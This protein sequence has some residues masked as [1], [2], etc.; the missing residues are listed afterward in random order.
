VLTTCILASS[1]AFVD[2]SVV[3]VGLPAIG[4]SL[5]GSAAD[6]QWIVNAYLLPLSALLLLGGALGDR[7]GRRGILIFGVALFGIGSAGCAAAPGVPS[8]LAARALQGIGAALLLPNSLAILGSAFSG[9]A[10]GRAVGT[11]SAS[12]S[13]AAAL[14]PVLG[15]W[16]IDVVGWRAIFLLN[17][18]LAAGAIALAALFVREPEQE[19][20]PARLDFAGALLASLALGA[21]TWGLTVGSGRAGWSTLAFAAI[22][23]GAVLLLAFLWIERARGDAAMMPL[24][25]FASSDYVGLTILTALLYGALG[26]LLVLVPYLL[27]QGMGFSGTAAGAALVPFPVV[28]A[29]SSRTMGGIAGRIG[30]RLPLSIGPAIVGIG[31]LLLLRVADGSNYWSAIFPALLAISVGMAG[32]V[33]PLTT[34]VLMSVDPRHMGSASGLNSAVARTGG[35]IATAL[36]GGVFAAKGAQLFAA[37]H[38][39]V[40]AC[41]IASIAAGAAAFL[42]V[43]R[44]T[45][46]SPQQAA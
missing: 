25:I 15:G 18:P 40:I 36:L 7:F 28:L 44:R 41:A 1:L 35:L 4:R 45:R 42:L 9:E 6:L 34:A 24:A 39:A 3:N 46:Q 14:G 31:F 43:S 2:G 13:A 12:S 21:L 22:A 19:A 30:S 11:W 26:A 37:F 32:A 29:L 5:Q 23:S 20:N 27:I 8:L 17:L 33:A 38:V 16:L 10:R